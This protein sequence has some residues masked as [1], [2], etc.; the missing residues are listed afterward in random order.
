MPFRTFTEDWP[1][2][3]IIYTA[4]LPSALTG[5]DIVIFAAAFAYIADITSVENRTSRVTVLEVTY[6]ITF[7]TGI[8]LGK[9]K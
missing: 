8:A 3:Y 7:P 4:T 2:E 9:N 5:V 1:V 6:L